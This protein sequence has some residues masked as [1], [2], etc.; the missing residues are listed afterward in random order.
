MAKFEFDAAAIKAIEP[1]KKG[2][3]VARDSK[4]RGLGIR[5]LPS[6]SRAFVL[7]YV[8]AGRRRIFTLGTFPDMTV[9]G[10]RGE[11]IK[12]KALIKAGAGS[13][14]PAQSLKKAREAATMEE[15]C[16]HFR[17]E[18]TDHLRQ[19]TRS[20]YE[21]MLDNDILPEFGKRK[22]A[23]IEIEDIRKLHRK[24]SNPQGRNAPVA[25]NLCVALLSRLFS[26]AIER[27]MISQNPVKGLRRNPVDRRTRYLTENENAALNTAL[28]NHPNQ[29]I[30]DIFR[31]LMLTGARKSEARAAEWS[32]FE[33]SEGY[34]IKGAGKVKQKREHRVFLGTPVRSLL[35]RRNIWRSEELR[36]IKNAYVAVSAEKKLA[37]DEWRYR[38][39]RFVFPSRDGQTGH[40]IEIKGDWDDLCTA[41]SI[42]RT[43]KNA[44]R[45][46]D[47][48]HSYA[49][50]LASGGVSL[51]MIG[52]LLGHSQISTTLRY[53]HL[54][55]GPLREAAEK[56]ATTIVTRGRSAKVINLHSKRRNRAQRA[57]A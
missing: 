42:P 16:G 25:A 46:H 30:A 15:L 52:E 53:S 17:K 38:V 18:H 55:D 21:R 56:A 45:I 44:V 7:D 47:L 3:R 19:S 37:L 24:I 28:E 6:G 34:W 5:V 9:A 54:F 49:S 26:V 36:R 11:A 48:R 8:V 22:V 51:Q 33:M 27:K 4:V 35:E 43:G 13:Y 41:A 1:P 31:L 10:A 12:E 20:D 23:S 32:E 50:V 39:E 2:I 14:D 40:L 57:I 29:D